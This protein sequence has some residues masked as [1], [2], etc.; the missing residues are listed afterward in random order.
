MSRTW[1]LL[2]LTL[3]VP[4][5]AMDVAQNPN[6]STPDEEEQTYLKGFEKSAAKYRLAR[7]AALPDPAADAAAAEGAR[8]ANHRVEVGR[9]TG[10]R[11]IALK[12]LKQYP[13]AASASTLQHA[14]VTTY[15]R[16]GKVEKCRDALVYLW[17]A[18]P[19]HPRMGDALEDALAA[20]EKSLRF[21][22]SVHLESEDPRKVVVLSGSS[23][24]DVQMFRFIARN[25][26]RDSQAPRASLGYARSLLISSDK[27]DYAVVRSAYEDFLDEYPEH[28]L[29]FSALCELA[30]SHLV[31]Y[32]GDRYDVGA[33]DHA[34]LVIDQAE[35][36]TRGDAA[37]AA[38]VEAYRRRIRVW[39]QQRDLQVA[40]WYRDRKRPPFL[41]WLKEPS[42][43]NWSEGARYYYNEV[44]KRDSTSEYARVAKRELAELPP[45]VDPLAGALPAIGSR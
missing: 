8:K 11:R 37:R 35:L 25:G 13:Y 14:L 21:N 42:H 22:A 7:A 24:A 27:R 26:D 29:A 30:L 40:R 16:M 28:Q 9:L 10:A 15:A 43:Q 20:A 5:W 2:V 33:L 4:L 3:I 6:Q 45:A 19:D 12:T 31:T 1:L 18:Y 34:A 23:Y 17:Y 38:Q 41:A 32:R 44:I 39:H 36:E